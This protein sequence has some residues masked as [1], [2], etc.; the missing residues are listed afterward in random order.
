MLLFAAIVFATVINR[1]VQQ[2]KR[3]SILRSIAV[4]I[5]LLLVAAVAGL[6]LRFI[7]PAIATQIPEYT[8]FSELGFE[9]L[10]DWY[11]YYRRYL[12]G[13]PLENTSLSDL[14]SQLSTV[15]LLPMLMGLGVAPWMGLAVLGLYFAMQQL[16][17][18][19]QT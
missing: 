7:I 12:P 8:F 4:P 13:E 10:Q 16:E 2:L 18:T 17:G 15:S 1:L 11:R 6:V 3:G 5:V 19:V 9:Q 14:F